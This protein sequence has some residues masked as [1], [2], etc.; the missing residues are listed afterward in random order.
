LLGKNEPQTGP[1]PALQ[2]P[3]LIVY[4]FTVKSN[5]YEKWK[6]VIVYYFTVKSNAYKKWKCVIVYH[7]TVKSNAYK[8]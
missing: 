5:A 2:R 3:R 4:H 7:F 1:L 6:F 8:K